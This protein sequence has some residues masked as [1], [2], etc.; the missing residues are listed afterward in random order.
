MYYAALLAGL[1]CFLLSTFI[2]FYLLFIIMYIFMCI[3]EGQR[4]H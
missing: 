3:T 1:Q 4:E 2:I